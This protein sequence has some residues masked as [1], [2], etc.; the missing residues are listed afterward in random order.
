MLTLLTTLEGV[1]LSFYGYSINASGQ[2]PTIPA[3]I[4]RI[5]RTAS[6]FAAGE[7]MAIGHDMYRDTLVRFM[8]EWIYKKTSQSDFSLSV[9][10]RHY[11]LHGMDAGNFYRPQDVHRPVGA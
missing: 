4:D 5:K 1:M 9:L 8:G 10:N 7:P 6:G 2:K 3:L 11:V